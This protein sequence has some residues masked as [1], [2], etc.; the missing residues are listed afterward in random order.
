M[1]VAFSFV[2]SSCVSL[3]N[4]R[5]ATLEKI[6]EAENSKSKRRK[7][8]IKIRAEAYSEVPGRSWLV[9]VAGVLGG[10]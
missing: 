7:K 6:E 8:T 4:K 10:D 1:F 2:L 9:E 5:T 3:V